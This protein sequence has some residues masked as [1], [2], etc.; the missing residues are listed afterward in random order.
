[1]LGLGRSDFLPSPGSGR[2]I[3]KNLLVQYQVSEIEIDTEAENVDDHQAETGEAWLLAD[4]P[5][6]VDG[7][8]SVKFGDSVCSV[9]GYDA[10]TNAAT[11]QV[12][13]D[14]K[15]G[16]TLIHICRSSVGTL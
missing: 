14:D 1:M 3:E 7:A 10:A 9:G 15:A 5:E 11:N 4:T 13:E 6:N 2:L 8:A 16:Q 12:V